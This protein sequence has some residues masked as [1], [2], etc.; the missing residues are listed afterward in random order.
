MATQREGF[1]LD[2]V[3][4]EAAR[5]RFVYHI[6]SDAETPSTLADTYGWYSVEGNP[7]YAPGEGGSAGRYLSAAA[8]LTPEF[9]A[10][11]AAKY[12][13][14]PGATIT[15]APPAGSPK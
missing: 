7:A 3:T 9:V 12:L 14:R 2:P 4:F 11:T 8:A 15:V 13:D 6:L 10:A 1:A 5:R